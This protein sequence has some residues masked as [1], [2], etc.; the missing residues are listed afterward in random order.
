MG[1]K[2]PRGGVKTLG[3]K[4]P[5]NGVSTGV[6][7]PTLVIIYA[8]AYRSVV[9][10]NMSVTVIFLVYF[11]ENRCGLLLRTLSTHNIHHVENARRGSPVDMLCSH[12]YSHLKC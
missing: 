9:L 7:A 11:Q 2:T 3:V 6:N 12:L 4:T 10:S 8:S 5:A 1:V